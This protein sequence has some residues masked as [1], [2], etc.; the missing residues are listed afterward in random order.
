MKG[1]RREAKKRSAPENIPPDPPFVKGGRGDLPEA[2]GASVLEENILSSILDGVVAVDSRLRITLV[3][4]AA[5]GLTRRK[6]QELIGRLFAEVFPDNHHLLRFLEETIETGRSFADHDAVFRYPDGGQVPVGIATTLLAE[7]EGKG[8]G[9]VVVLREQGKVRELE[10]QIV[11]A[12]KLASL[13]VLAAGMAHE[14]KNPLAGIRGAAQLLRKEVGGSS[15]G[16]YAEVIVQEADRLNGIVEGLLALG[17]PA[18]QEYGGLNIHHLLDRVLRLQEVVAREQGVEI[19]REYDPSLPPVR[20]NE[21]SLVQVFLNV[22]RNALEAM[23]E[24][25]RLTVLTRLADP[26]A[27]IRHEGECRKLIQVGVADTGPG[28]PEAIRRDI[29]TPFFTTKRKGVGLGLAIAYQIVHEHQGLLKVETPADGGAVFWVAL[30]MW[31]E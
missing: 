10:D 9:A 26:F 1:V 18:E 12:E 7:P 21:G 11:R 13:G 16:E 27:T 8:T 19:A 4:R 20:G 25:G 5:E 29:F 6:A 30:P 14:I 28:I 23:P 17:R 3:N 31:M 2:R 22:I 15:L 24:G